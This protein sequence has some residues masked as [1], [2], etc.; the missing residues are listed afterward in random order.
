MNYFWRNRSWPIFRWSTEELLP[1]LSEARKK[2]GALV[3]CSGSLDFNEYEDHRINDLIRPLTR[4]KLIVWS[5]QQDWRSIQGNTEM[6]PVYIGAE[7]NRLIKWFNKPSI[8]GLIRAGIAYLWLTSIKPFNSQNEEVAFQ[9]VDLALAQD[10]KLSLRYYKF[11]LYVLSDQQKYLDVLEE[12]QKGDLDITAWLKWFLQIYI[13][14]LSD[15]IEKLKGVTQQ[16]EYWKTWKDRTLNSRQ[17][18]ILQ[19]ILDGHIDHITNRKYVSLLKTSA[20]SAKRDLIDLTQKDILIKGAAK[21]R[22]TSYSLKKI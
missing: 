9:M 21:G 16:I 15:S 18:Q 8:D 1:L 17:R 13:K 2:Q 3:S 14:A 20:E 12:T 5:Q 4:E 11:S 19:N 6:D 10:E 22:S 7:I